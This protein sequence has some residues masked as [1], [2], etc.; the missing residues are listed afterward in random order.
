MR[1]NTYIVSAASVNQDKVPMEGDLP[2]S[3]HYEADPG[4]SNQFQGIC[5]AWL[6]LTD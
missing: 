3:S 2:G 4:K 5:F 1:T 6:A